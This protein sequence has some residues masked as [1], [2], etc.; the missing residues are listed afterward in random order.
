V[1]TFEARPR[2]GRSG[3][4][5]VAR[6]RDAH[7]TRRTESGIAVLDMMQLLYF[8]EARQRTVAEYSEL[9][10]ATSLE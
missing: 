8:G 10:R 5:G 7:R 1:L 2:Q 3:Q 4:G 6:H 9:F